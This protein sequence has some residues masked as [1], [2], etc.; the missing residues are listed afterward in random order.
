MTWGWHMGIAAQPTREHRTITVDFRSE[1][2][3]FQRLGN[4]KTFLTCVLAFVMSLGFQ[5]THKATDQPKKMR[6][7][8]MLGL[9]ALCDLFPLARQLRREGRRCHAIE[10][11]MRAFVVVLLPPLV[12]NAAR[13]LDRG[14]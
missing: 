2:T 3:D 6:P 9:R 8:I 10:G 1:A 11:S 5:L 12:N 7:V 14:A 13:V 4:G